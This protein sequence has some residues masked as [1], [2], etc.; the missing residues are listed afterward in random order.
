V[1]ARRWVTLAWTAWLVL[2]GADLPGAPA[3][4]EEAPRLRV[5]AAASLTEVVLGLAQRFDGAQV[6]PSFGGSSALA[7]QIRDGAPADV[8]LSASPDWMDDLREA[9]LLAG[10]P[11]VLARNRLVCIAPRGS[12]LADRGV[13]D[14]RA[15][16]AAIGP[17]GRIAIADEGVPAGEYARAALRHLGLA[18]DYAPHLVGQK[19]VRAVLHAVEQGELPAGFAYATDAKVASALVLFALDPTTHPA[20]EYQAAAL[21]GAPSPAQARRFVAFLRSEAARALL[22]DAGFAL[23]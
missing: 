23:P 15:L 14:P 1:T 10:R 12:P 5:F 19:D 16:L 20:I 11:I 6:E 2:L 17:D 7:R 21:K 22:A 3:R 4:A 18:A 9:G 8:F 13:R